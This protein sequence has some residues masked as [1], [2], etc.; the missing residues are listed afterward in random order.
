MTTHEVFGLF[1]DHLGANVVV[2][3]MRLKPSGSQDLPRILV[4]SIIQCRTDGFVCY[5]T[6]GLGPDAGA[7]YRLSL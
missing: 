4:L 1:L 3:R 5:M 2:Q 7:V 6:F